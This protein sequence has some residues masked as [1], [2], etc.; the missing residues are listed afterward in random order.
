[1][2]Q[3]ASPHLRPEVVIQIGLP[4]PVATGAQPN[5]GNFPGAAAVPEAR[6]G[7]RQIGGALLASPE[8]GSGDRWFD[9]ERAARSRKGSGVEGSKF[10]SHGSINS[11]T[12]LGLQKNSSIKI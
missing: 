9:R 10:G 12:K 5:V 2:V 7:H 11:S 8:G 6:H 1:M 4:H 3:D